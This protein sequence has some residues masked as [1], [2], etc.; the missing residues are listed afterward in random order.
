MHFVAPVLRN[1]GSQTMSGR[2][3]KPIEEEED[4]PGVH[5]CEICGCKTMMV[6][7]TIN[8][9]TKEETKKAC[10]ACHMERM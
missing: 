9:I 7:S 6:Y 1:K 10:P 5:T 2:D 3:E 4:D 8:I